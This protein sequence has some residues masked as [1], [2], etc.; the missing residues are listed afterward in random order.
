MCR[1]HH[2]RWTFLVL[3]CAASAVCAQGDENAG[4]RRPWA[5]GV[6]AQVDDESNDST[7]AS[8]NWGVS[9]RTW[10]EFAAGRSRSAERGAD[11]VADNLN[12]GLEHRFGFIGVAFDAEQWGDSA[13]LESTDFGA[14]IYMQNE[15]FRLGLRRER[16]AIDVHFTL[17]G[18]L[19]GTIRRTA[20]VDADG[21]ELNVRVQVGERW[22][23]HAS[24][25]TYDY[26]RNLAALPRI[27]QLNLLSASALTL[28]NSLVDEQA[29]FGVEWQTRSGQV[30]SLDHHRDRSAV[31]GSRLESFEIAFL[32]PVARRMDLEINLGQGRSDLLGSGVYGGLLLLI[33]GG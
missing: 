28:A 10:L 12:A 25:V 17:T 33:Y 5:I 13:A 21:T 23:L 32:F 14:S 1:A 19:G 20:G 15:R 2:L 6:G 7:L 26:S 24:A 3:V 8:F 4:D 30:L 22:Q 29:G 9:E 18:P 11:I 16:R 31:D 27:E